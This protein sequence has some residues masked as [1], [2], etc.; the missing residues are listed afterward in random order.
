MTTSA[1]TRDRMAVDPNRS[2]FRFTTTR[3]VAVS[4]VVLAVVVFGLVGLGKLPINLLPDIAYPTITIR[5]EYPG[6]SPEDVEERVSERIQEQVAVVQGVRRVTSISRAEVSDV[7]LEFLWGT[8]MVFAISDIRERLDRVR[9]PEQ[10]ER[11]L[12]LRYDPSLDPVMTIGLS[13]ADVDSVELRRIADEEIERELAK[14]EGVAAVKVR[15]GDEEEIRVSIDEAALAVL[16]LDVGLIATRLQE[17]NVNAAA[18]VI[19]EGKTEF[20]VRALGEFRNL[21]EV[22]DVILVNR[23]GAGIRLRD[24]ARVERIPKDKEV[25]S[26]VDGEPCVLIDVYKEAAANVVSMAAKVRQRAFGRDDQRAY[27]EKLRADGYDVTARAPPPKPGDD[28]PPSALVV[29]LVH[30]KVDDPAQLEAILVDQIELF[31]DAVAGVAGE[32]GE[33]LRTAGGEE[34]GVTVG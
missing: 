20:L 10:A 6:A 13:G 26:R 31:A 14:V 18:G 25:I 17:E 12:V 29:P 28:E 9:L 23:G 27:V 1:E 34:N 32:L 22:R 2:F 8:E 3:P 5:T 11:P 19:E 4:M 33:V 15:G 7:V 16:G 24:V 21:D 30:R